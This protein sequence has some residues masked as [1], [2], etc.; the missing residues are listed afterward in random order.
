M[1]DRLIALVKNTTQF[2]IPTD[3][4]IPRLTNTLHTVLLFKDTSAHLESI[5]MN[6]GGNVH[7]CPHS[8]PA[9]VIRL[10]D[11]IGT[12]THSLFR[13]GKMNIVGAKSTEHAR[14]L[15]QRMR[16]YIEHIKGP[17]RE[18][19][20][21][22]LTALEDRMSFNNFTLRNI[23]ATVHLGKRPNLAHLQD[24]MPDLARWAPDD[25]PGLKLLV[26]LRP[27]D[28]CRCVL[29]KN[30]RN[31]KCNIVAVLF[32]TG[33]LNLCGCRSIA[34]INLAMFKLKNLFSEDE[35]CDY[36]AQLPKELRTSARRQA[37]AVEFGG[38]ERKKR[39]KAAEPDFAVLPKKVKQRLSR[40]P[41]F[42]QACDLGQ[43]ENV[44]TMIQFQPD[45]VFERDLSGCTALER[46]EKIPPSAQ[47]DSHR[48]IIEILKNR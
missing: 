7:S 24:I 6:S 8:F 11:T 21:I 39:K 20:R 3:S 46:L 48:R 40:N 26:W 13:S 47:T 41:I 43:V 12:A 34:D 44:L 9:L 45:V 16:Y 37:I 10:K 2:Q 5:M 28:L 22:I 36:T 32:D 35:Y 38:F 18:G 25:F 42:I 17:F 14:Y 23:V 4:A 33:K 15:G 19:G 31:C 27:K 1:Y 30:K 29:K